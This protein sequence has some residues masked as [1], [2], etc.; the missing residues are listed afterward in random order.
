MKAKIVVQDDNRWCMKNSSLRLLIPSQTGQNE[1]PLQ[2][3]K[4]AK[5]I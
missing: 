5:K 2:S 1:L 3:N 4:L